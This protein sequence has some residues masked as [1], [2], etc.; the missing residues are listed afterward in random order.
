VLGASA[1]GGTGSTS[2]SAQTAPA[3]AFSSRSAAKGQLPFTG[4]NVGLLLL[5]GAGCLGSGLALRRVRGN[6]S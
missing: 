4:F 6:Q 3:S 5:L 1:S 2:G